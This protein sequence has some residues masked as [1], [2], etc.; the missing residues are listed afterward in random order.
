MITRT[1]IPEEMPAQAD[2]LAPLRAYLGPDD[3]R[4]ARVMAP[5]RECY[6]GSQRDDAVAQ[7]IRRLIANSLL[8]RDPRRPASIGNRCDGS[9]FVVIGASGSGKSRALHEAL[10][11][12]PAF[13][14]Y[15]VPESGCPLVRVHARSPCTLGQLG[16]AILHAIGYPTRR[17][18]KENEAWHRV[19]QQLPPY[20]VLFLLIEDI[21]NVLRQKNVDE[22][23]K[24]ADTLRSLMIFP[25]WPVQLL[26]TATEEFVAF[27]GA[28][29]QFSRRLKYV[30]FENV[31]PAEDGEWIERAVTDFAGSAGLKLSFAEEDMMIPR[32]CRAAAFQMG[33]V[34]EIL[35]DAVEVAIRARRRTLAIGDFSEAYS[36]RVTERDLNMFLSPTWFDIDPTLVRRRGEKTEEGL[37]PAP[38]APRRSR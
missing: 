18:L 15:G 27:A 2:P 22:I 31:H 8:P 13:P 12:H 38:R 3:A 7:E 36:T 9:G 1:P 32:L 28:D 17:A 19:S 6:V 30:P 20:G 35:L 5:L 26:L 11:R 37:P 24:V 34:F 16:T 10:V 21:H 33:L 25:E 14:G 23:K 4:V 29:R